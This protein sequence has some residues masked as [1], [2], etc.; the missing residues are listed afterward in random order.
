MVLIFVLKSVC[1]YYS[2]MFWFCF[3]DEDEK[4]R[5]ERRNGMLRARAEEEQ[6]GESKEK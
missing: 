5:M 3:E 4:G 1:V 6:E 2:N